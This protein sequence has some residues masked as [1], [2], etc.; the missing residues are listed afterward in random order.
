MKKGKL[1]GT[2]QGLMDQAV[3]R[4]A[5]GTTLGDAA[6]RKARDSNPDPKATISNYLEM[7][8]T[9]RQGMKASDEFLLRERM[10]DPAQLP[11]A[12]ADYTRVWSRMRQ[13]RIFDVPCLAWMMLYHMSD[14]WIDEVIGGSDGWK[15]ARAD[16]SPS[17]PSSLDRA[18]ADRMNA[19]YRSEEAQL[20][21][22][23]HL[24]FETTYIGFGRGAALSYVGRE[25]RSFSHARD[26]WLMGYVINDADRSID[27]L[28]FLEEEGGGTAT[29]LFPVCWQGRYEL[30]SVVTLSPLIC[31]TLIDFINEHRTIIVEKRPSS[32]DR[33]DFRK[34]GKRQRTNLLPMP[35]Y[36]VPLRAKLIQERGRQAINRVGRPRVYSHRYDVRGHERVRI[37]RGVLPLDPKKEKKLLKRGY[38]IYTNRDH[39]KRDDFARMLERKVPLLRTGEWVAILVSWVESFVKGPPDAPYIPAVRQAEKM[40]ISSED[41]GT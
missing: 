23:Q 35:Y 12:R 7:M 25:A 6:E 20:P 21:W 37:E 24:P 29:S 10:H 1:A 5:D 4:A 34:S 27:E 33:Y 2:I 15:P 16:G 8:E 14:R 30:L 13:A 41:Q 31:H 39:I 19:Y 38:R 17:D 9:L 22:P 28:V 11:Q 26:A 40:P 3:Y 32:N 36:I 18:V